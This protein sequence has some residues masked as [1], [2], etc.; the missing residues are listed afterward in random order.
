VVDKIDD[1]TSSII[2][3]NLNKASYYIDAILSHEQ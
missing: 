1:I 2:I 3:N